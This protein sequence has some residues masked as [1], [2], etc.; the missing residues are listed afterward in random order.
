MGCS[1][2]ILGRWTYPLVPDSN[3]IQTQYEYTL[4]GI[5]KEP[6]VKL[7]D[8]TV[9]KG[10]VV[11]G[12]GCHIGKNTRISNS[13]LGRGVIIGQGC[14]LDGVYIMEGCSIG[15]GSKLVKCILSAGVSV[16][17]ESVVS[18]G[19]LLGPGVGFTLFLLHK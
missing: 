7:S 12:Q 19:C 18:K 8:S 2:D 10:K 16:G 1:K 9:L 4:P 13:V 11:L 5:Y 3:Y 14:V 6:N 17:V 15:P